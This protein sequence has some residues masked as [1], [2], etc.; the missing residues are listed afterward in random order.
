[1]SESPHAL[2][3]KIEFLHLEN[4]QLRTTIEDLQTAVQINKQSLKAMI[5]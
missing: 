1:M 3:A 5:A 2:K 4:Q